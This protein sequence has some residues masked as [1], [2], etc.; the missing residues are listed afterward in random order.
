MNDD[1]FKWDG[2]FSKS[3]LDLI[4][5]CPALFKHRV[6]D[7]NRDKPSPA[8][9]MGT[10]AHVAILEPDKWATAYALAPN[11][12]RRTKAGKEAYALWQESL[13]P[14]TTVLKQDAWDQVTGMAEAVKNCEASQGLLNPQNREGLT[15]SVVVWDDE[16]TGAPCKGRVDLFFPEAADTDYDGYV[17]DLK[18]TA[19]ASPAGFAKSCAN[20]R[21]HVQAAMYL[22]GTGADRFFFVCVER[23]APYLTAVYELCDDAIELGRQVMADDLEYALAC[24]AADSF[25]GYN[26]HTQMTTIDLPGWAYR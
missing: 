17:V 14:H 2:R 3:S 15:E 9:A 6:I 11:V 20:F 13:A 8:M 19:D 24:V 4:A 21:Y 26:Q 12:D 5:K 7:G 23:R 25:P 16:A 1:Y 18:T 22:E 10:A